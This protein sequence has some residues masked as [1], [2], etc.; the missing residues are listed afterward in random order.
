MPFFTFGQFTRVFGIGTQ[1]RGTTMRKLRSWAFRK[2]RTF[3][4]WESPKGSYCCSKSTDFEILG[5][6]AKLRGVTKK[7]H[8]HN[9]DFL[10]LKRIAKV[11]HMVDQTCY[12]FQTRKLKIVAVSFFLTSLI[13]RDKHT[14]AALCWLWAAITPVK[15]IVRPKST[16]FSETSGRELSHGPILEKFSHQKISR[17]RVFSKNRRFLQFFMSAPKKFSNCCQSDNFDPRRSAHGSS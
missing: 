2:C 1:I 8:G 6:L 14:F 17:R 7:S 13:F 9:F 11:T 16:T 4:V 12:S 5:P 10:G 3:W 15:K